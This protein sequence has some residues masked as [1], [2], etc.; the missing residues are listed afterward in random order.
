M[1]RGKG[2]LEEQ[3][4]ALETQN[5]SETISV[6]K[7]KNRAA[8]KYCKDI[9][10]LNKELSKKTAALNQVR[11][12]NRK[13]KQMASKCEDACALQEKLKRERSITRALRA[14]L[15]D[16]EKMPMGRSHEMVVQPSPIVGC[17]PM[18]DPML[19]SPTRME[20]KLHEL[21]KELKRR[22]Y[23][24]T[25]GYPPAPPPSPVMMD[26]DQE[27]RIKKLK[28][29]LREAEEELEEKEAQLISAREE[30][31]LLRSRTET[32]TP[33]LQARV[34]ELV[35]ECD[36][37]DLEIERLSAELQ[38]CER[39]LPPPPEPVESVI[40]PPEKQEEIVTKEEEEESTRDIT[41][42][43]ADIIAGISGPEEKEEEVTVEKPQVVAGMITEEEHNKYVAGCESK[44]QE[45]LAQNKEYKGIV[46][47]R[48][49]KIAQLE[50][51]FNT[52]AEETK[53]MAEILEKRNNA[54]AFSL[55]W[56]KK[57]QGEHP[58]IEQMP[59]GPEIEEHVKTEKE[60]EPTAEIK[61]EPTEEIKPEPTEEGELTP[62]ER[63][64]VE[65]AVEF[66]KLVDETIR[67]NMPKDLGQGK[68]DPLELT[69]EDLKPL[70]DSARG[71]DKDSP[72]SVD[73]MAH[74][75]MSLF[76][77]NFM[78]PFLEDETFDADLKANWIRYICPNPTEVGEDV[79]G[80]SRTSLF[81]SMFWVE[82]GLAKA[83]SF[84]KNSPP[85]EK[86]LE[87]MVD[88]NLKCDQ[89]IFTIGESGEVTSEQLKPII[90]NLKAL[91]KSS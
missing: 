72:E 58:E 66:L 84:R 46:A 9:N 70:E 28:K 11:A 63:E 25:G 31:A 51:D 39:P 67:K 23:A 29:K 45:L 79:R 71:Y 49:A 24:Q 85:V 32:T 83:K 13:L 10:Q 76:W 12:E 86:A 42:A 3:C 44:I 74:E 20:W 14:Q 33:E 56:I 43:I 53:N 65:Y 78:S 37:K 35:R 50:T 77:D 38:K 5:K 59:T 90:E 16:T 69:P 64:Q 30:L 87:L 18:R 91:Y 21:K 4:A 26:E 62:E 52:L 19:A 41:E 22:E 68:I 27:K 40:P 1:S 60:P 36:L 55:N 54:L 47:E 17:E 57:I 15:K 82:G 88:Q 61:P 34:E 7:S 80:V 75:I 73:R 89:A 2:A 8:N 6:L 48:D 81:R